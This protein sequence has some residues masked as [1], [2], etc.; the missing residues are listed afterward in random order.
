MEKSDWRGYDNPNILQSKVPGWRSFIKRE[1]FFRHK[2]HSL[3]P[4]HPTVDIM[5]GDLECRYTHPMVDGYTVPFLNYPWLRPNRETTPAHFRVLTTDLQETDVVAGAL[6]K[7]Q[8]QLD[9]AIS[10]MPEDSFVI[11]NSACVPDVTGENLEQVARPWQEKNK[12]VFY[13]E[14]DG[15]DQAPGFVTKIIKMAGHGDA[16][17]KNGKGRKNR[18]NLLGCPPGRVQTELVDVLKRAGLDVAS[19]VVPSVSPGKI[20]QGRTA[21]LNVIMPNKLYEGLFSEVQRAVDLP[22]IRPASPYGLEGTGRWL[23]AIAEAAGVRGWEGAWSDIEDKWGARWEALKKEAAQCRLGF[24]LD[25]SELSILSDAAMNANCPLVPLLKEMGFGIDFLIHDP[26][27]LFEQKDG[28]HKIH[29]FGT[30]EEM[31]EKIRALPCRAFYTDCFFDTRLTR[32]GKNQFNLEFFEGGIEGGFRTFERL[33]GVSRMPFYGRYSR[34][35][36]QGAT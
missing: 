26:R 22:W 31:D 10:Q 29:T 2:Y 32:N 28:R 25:P 33:L 16:N 19:C 24:V 4:S 35:L 12:S 6:H 23:I 34:F 3:V 36:T 8:E 14:S 5:H 18:I 1:A 7:A 27:G 30:P 21:S 9:L 15:E 20:K 11:L 17:N 13:V